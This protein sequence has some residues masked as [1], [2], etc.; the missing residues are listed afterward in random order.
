MRLRESKHEIPMNIAFEENESSSK[1]HPFLSASVGGHFVTFLSPENDITVA[2]GSGN[3]QS[4]PTCFMNLSTAA[5][6]DSTTE[7]TSKNI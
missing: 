2:Q 5:A 1:I 3:H 4:W 6:C 7:R